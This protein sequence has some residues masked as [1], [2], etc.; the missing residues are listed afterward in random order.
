MVLMCD[1]TGF[2]VPEMVKTRP[3][4]II[5][6]NHMNRPG[7]FTVVPISTTAPRKAEFYHFKFAS[8][9]MPGRIGE[10]WA[11]CD[12]VVSVARQRLDRIKVSRGKFDV[13]WVSVPDLGEIR[14][15]AAMSFGVEI[16]A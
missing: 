4:V 15:R 16:C 2:I 9:P 12:M 1:F 13:G 8:N 7:L 14:R 5:S 10:S 11:K 6:P 3:V